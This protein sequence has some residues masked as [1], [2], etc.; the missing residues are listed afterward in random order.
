FWSTAM[1]KTINGEAQ[2]HVLVDGKKIIITESFVRRDIQLADKED[3]GYKFHK[4]LGDSLV[5]AASIASSLK[6]QQDSEDPSKQEELMLFEPDEAI[7]P[8][9]V[10]DV[11]VFASEEVLYAEQEAK[12]AREKKQTTNKS[13][14]EIDNGSQKVNTFEDFRTELVEGKEKRAGTELVQEITKKQ[15]WDQQWQRT[16]RHRRKIETSL[17]KLNKLTI[18]NRYPLPRIDDLFDQLQGSQYFAKI[19]LQSGYH[20][21]RV[22]GDDISKTAFRTRYGHF[23][24]TVMPF[25]AKEV[26]ITLEHVINGYGIHVDPSEIEAV[27]N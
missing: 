15:K 4:E 21:L 7:N 14:T 25:V 17:R 16:E 13:S 8:V 10:H 23:E 27:K 12:R 6:A 26:N 3:K 1:T 2:L 19:D 9:S 20:H 18:K 11:N 22:H 5:R 24:L